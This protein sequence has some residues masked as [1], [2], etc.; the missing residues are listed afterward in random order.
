MGAFASRFVNEG[1]GG[2]ADS[3]ARHISLGAGTYVSLAAA[4]YPALTGVRGYRAALAKC[5]DE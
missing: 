2:A 1:I 3:I 5:D 4:L